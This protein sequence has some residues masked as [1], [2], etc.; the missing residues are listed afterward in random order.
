MRPMKG[1]RL[2]AAIP[3][4]LIWVAA[5][6]SAT[7]PASPD[8]AAAAVSRPNVLWVIWDTV[9]ADRLGLYGPRY[10]AC[11]RHFVST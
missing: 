8:T 9:R 3:L 11:S 2:L 5:C 6:A 7:D 10:G 4:S 1:S